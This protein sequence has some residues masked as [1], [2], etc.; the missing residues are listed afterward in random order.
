[1]TDSSTVGKKL[2]SS[3]TRNG[4]SDLVNRMGGNKISE[5]MLSALM[6][7]T[8]QVQQRKDWN[9]MLA[10]CFAS[11]PIYGR[12]SPARI[13]PKEVLNRVLYWLKGKDEDEDEDED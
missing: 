13:L 5:R 1:M 12:N 4:Y 6:D 9:R 11:H 2:T 10:M 7:L 8:V 3:D